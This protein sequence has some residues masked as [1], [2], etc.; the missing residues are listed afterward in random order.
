MIIFNCRNFIQGAYSI[1]D[2]Y[3]QGCL[4]ELQYEYSNMIPGLVGL[5]KRYS[6][7]DVK[8]SIYSIN[9]D[10]NGNLVVPENC[11]YSRILRLLEFG[12]EG[13]R[14]THILSLS[15]NRLINALEMRR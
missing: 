14:P 3:I 9:I 15:K 7:D 12:G 6:L 10:S 4:V 8:R 13:I 1:R 5:L 2:L 11:E